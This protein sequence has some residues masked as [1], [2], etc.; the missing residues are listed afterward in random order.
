MT[1]LDVFLTCVA[2]VILAIAVLVTR[3]FTRGD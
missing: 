1:P 3:D 2:V